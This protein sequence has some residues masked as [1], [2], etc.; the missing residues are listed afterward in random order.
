MDS[1]VALSST[2]SFVYSAVMTVMIAFGDVSKAAD[3]YYESSAMVLG[4]VMLGKHLEGRSIEKTKGA[5]TGLMKLVPD[6]ATLIKDGEPF[7]T[8]ASALRAGDIVLV[9]PGERIP[10]D[11]L[12][13][14][15]AGSA[16]ESM[17]TGESMP[18][19]KDVGSAVTGG[20]IN[21]DG[22]LYVKTENMH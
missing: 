21:L 19:Y 16:D 12:V 6:K 1:L 8:D 10:M 11:G 2:A 14:E 13:T 20:S 4:F 9:R 17:F 15:G 5:I 7:E 18:V 3:L 22:V